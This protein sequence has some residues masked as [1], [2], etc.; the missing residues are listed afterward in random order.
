MSCLTQ[1]AFISGL[2]FSTNIGAE[3]EETWHERFWEMK[4]NVWVNLDNSPPVLDDRGK[5]LADSSHAV[6]VQVDR[7]PQPASHPT[8][9][10]D[11]LHIDK[12][13]TQP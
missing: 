2:H 4:P 13:Y 3:P 12:K 6:G 7:V 1:N 11:H 8:R 10:V 5:S 9:V